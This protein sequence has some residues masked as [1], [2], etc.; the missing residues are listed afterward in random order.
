MAD[1]RTKLNKASPLCTCH[2]A[3]ALRGLVEPRVATDVG[4]DKDE[5]WHQSKERKRCHELNVLHTSLSV[6][7]PVEV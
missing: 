3:C 7:A 4:T 2:S 1:V 5:K 6:C